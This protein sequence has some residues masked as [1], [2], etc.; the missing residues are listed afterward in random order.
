MQLVIESVA[1]LCA[2][3]AIVIVLHEWRLDKHKQELEDD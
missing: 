2:I 3:S 1:I